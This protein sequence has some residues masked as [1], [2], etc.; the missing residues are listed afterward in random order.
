MAELANKR[1]VAAVELL[2]GAFELST[3]QLAGNHSLYDA[4][5]L[6]LLVKPHRIV[7]VVVLHF[8]I[9]LHLFVELQLISEVF[10]VLG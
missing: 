5:V 10:V 8:A 2:D 3:R 1:M 9:S 6:Q 4:S 7:R